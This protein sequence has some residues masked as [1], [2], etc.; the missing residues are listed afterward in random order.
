MIVLSPV[1]T[2]RR[3]LA[4]PHNV[5][6]PFHL[7]CFSLQKNKARCTLERFWGKLKP[8]G[9]KNEICSNGSQQVLSRFLDTLLFVLFFYLL[10]LLGYI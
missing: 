2:D 7:I 1:Q 8:R 9:P 5:F 4:F 6:V 10:Y 3:G